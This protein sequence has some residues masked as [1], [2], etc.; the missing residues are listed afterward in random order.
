MNC[1]ICDDC[2]SRSF[3]KACAEWTCDSHI[4]IVSLALA[5]LVVRSL[6]ALP[7][8][9]LLHGALSASLSSTWRVS[10][11]GKDDESS[12]KSG[13]AGSTIVDVDAT[14]WR[15][16]IHIT[17]PVER[18]TIQ[19]AADGVHNASHSPGA[20]PFV[21][22]T[23]VSFLLPIHP[24]NLSHFAFAFVHSLHVHPGSPMHG[25]LFFSHS[26]HLVL[27]MLVQ[28]KHTPFFLL[29]GRAILMKRPTSSQ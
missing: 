24:S 4:A 3:R 18:T 2:T 10:I 12:R 25:H 1:A 26:P 16:R 6:F 9:S 11:L 28:H 27:R 7:V 15:G 20:F 21:S 14:G 17:A 22:T 5:I 8:F 29:L 19:L 23:F 13:V